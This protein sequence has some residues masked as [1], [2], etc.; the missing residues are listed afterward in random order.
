M[1][2]TQNT[3]HFNDGSTPLLNS[4]QSLH[5]KWIWSAL[6]ILAVCAIFAGAVVGSLTLND[7]ERESIETSVGVDPIE[8][9]IPAETAKDGKFA[10]KGLDLKSLVEA[11]KNDG[12]NKFQLDESTSTKDTTRYVLNEVS[13]VCKGTGTVFQ[14]GID[15]HPNRMGKLKQ[16]TLGSMYLIPPKTGEGIQ[17]CEI[18]I[19]DNNT[20]RSAQKQELLG[21]LDDAED[22][23]S[24]KA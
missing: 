21:L 19:A 20:M 5:K 6:K 13:V 8:V 12:E 3:S 23:R 22:R 17:D 10:L 11:W 2:A 7:V 18:K 16:P 1:L 24:S 15:F 4:S 9:E 14:V